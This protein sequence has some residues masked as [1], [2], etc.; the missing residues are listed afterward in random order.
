MSGRHAPLAARTWRRTP[1]SLR[2]RVLLVATIT[3]AT[4][5]LAMLFFGVLILMP[6]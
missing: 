5:A 1:G 3:A 6:R 4:A 2:D